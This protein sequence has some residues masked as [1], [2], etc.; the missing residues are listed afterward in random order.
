MNDDEHPT[1][2]SDFRY[3]ENDRSNKEAIIVTLLFVGVV[4]MSMALVGLD[5]NV[6][7]DE[8]ADQGTSACRGQGC[9]D[10][11]RVNQYSLR[12][13]PPRRGRARKPDNH[14]RERGNVSSSRLYYRCYSGR[15][16]NQ[17]ILARGS[18]R[19]Q[20]MHIVH[21]GPLR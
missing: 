20:T 11:F 9:V 21:C 4:G 10:Q 18:L 7:I 1:T 8:A 6:N 2:D 12:T 19:R 13:A 17:L 14:R 15:S 3:E 16:S 5:I